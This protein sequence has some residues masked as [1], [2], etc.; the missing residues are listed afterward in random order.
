MKKN[1]HLSV[2]VAALSIFGAGVPAA[3]AADAAKTKEQSTTVE[4]LVVTASR[5]EEKLQDVPIAVQALSGDKLQELGITDFQKLLQFLPDVHAAGRGPGQNTVYIRGLSTDTASILIG[6]SA[7]TNPNVAVYLDD[8]AVS[9]PVR[10]L[11][12]YAADLERIEVLK[13]PQGSLFGASAMGGAVRYITAKPDLSG[14]HAG[15]SGSY[16]VTKSGDPSAGGQVFV[17]VPI[18]ADKLGV[19]LVVYSDHK[20]GYIDN[21]AG[22]YQMPLTSPGFRGRPGFATIPR[23]VV[24]NGPLVKENFNFADY[25]GLRLSVEYRINDNWSIEAQHLTQTLNTEG[26]FDY[27]PT[28]GDLK[29]KRFN[30]DSL[31]DKGDVSAWTVK[32]RLGQLDLL[33]TGGYINRRAVQRTDYTNYSSS[34][35]YA[36]YYNCD[37][38]AYVHAYGGSATLPATAACH[39]PKNHVFNQTR[40]TRFTEE[41]RVATPADWR[42]RAIGGIYYDS[43]HI[44]SQDHFA[45]EGSLESGFPSQNTPLTTVT[46]IDRNITDPTVQFINDITRSDRQM[47]VFGEVAYDILPEK[48]TLTVGGRFYDQ[49]VS[50]AGGASFGSRFSQAADHG[51]P[52][53][54]PLFVPRTETG[55]IPKVNLTYKPRPGLM[56]YAT[57]SEGFRPGGFNRGGGTPGLVDPAFKVPVS[58]GTDTVK[59]YEIG[60]KTQFFDNSL[61][62]NGAAYYI[63]WD[64]LQSQVYRPK[65]S[66]LTFVQN[67]ADAEIKGV[68]GS[69]IWRGVPGL[70]VTSAFTYTHSELTRVTTGVSNLRPVGSQLAL[71]PELQGNIGVRYEREIA[72]GANGYVRTGAQAAGRMLSTIDRGA[73][74]FGNPLQGDFHLRAYQT[75]DAGIGVIKDNWTLE[76]FGENLSDTRAQLYA[77]ASDRVLRITTNRPRTFGV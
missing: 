41:F 12:I 6:G 45:Y 2:G 44:Y 10:N 25:Q 65:D 27:D 63:K 17:N 15:F 52:V 39:N 13:G 70:T 24:N 55:F 75:F 60:W 64:N 61:Q 54:G 8:V 34:G 51:R 20:G 69:L 28:L 53:E 72:G 5:R 73:D 23:P 3:S 29:V 66:F 68:E 58:Y 59:N 33:Y 47:A 56:V 14:Y 26:V 50:I 31:K 43:D 21:I 7:G 1:W 11:D 38:A 71:T 46:A 67:A 30:P 49:R 37:Y 76:V 48:L 4:D 32:G 22:T 74:A 9:M 57:Y 16:S 35:P 77:N 19:R 42:L 36:V 62:L 18:I 40:N